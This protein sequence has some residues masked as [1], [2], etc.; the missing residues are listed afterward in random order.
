MS[1][2]IL[3]IHR[4]LHKAI[5]TEMD[6]RAIETFTQATESDEQRTVG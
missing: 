4:K 5:S 1:F 6:E 2:E 3:I